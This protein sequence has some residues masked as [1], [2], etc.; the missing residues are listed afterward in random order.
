MNATI[1]EHPTLSRVASIRTRDRRLAIAIAVFVP[2]VIFIGFARSYYLK[3]LFGFP[4]LPSLLVH[5]HAAIMTAWVALFAVQVGLVASHRTRLH[6]KLGILGS[7]LALL[8]FVSGILVSLAAAARGSAI[9]GWEPLPFLVIPLG[10]ILAFGALV[11]TAI[12]YRRKLDTHKRL[13][14][15][16]ALNLMPAAVARIPLDFIQSNGALAFY[17]LPDLCVVAVVAY[18]TIKQRRLHPAYFWGASLL[19]LSHPLRIMLA[20]TDIWLRIADSVVALVR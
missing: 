17:G 3:T 15:L 9:P 8:V 18:D 5:I 1:T 16:S 20:D 12:Y 14:L 2:L 4:P 7:V 6:M 11:G 13:M 10:D 19:I